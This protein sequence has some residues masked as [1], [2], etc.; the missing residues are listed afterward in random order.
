MGEFA[1][2]CLKSLLIVVQNTRGNPEGASLQTTLASTR[3][4][5]HRSGASPQDQA[6]RSRPEVGGGADGSPS[7]VGALQ[8]SI[9]TPR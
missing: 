6:V 8:T 4:S 9:S 7:V 1:L 5:M 3:E 2:G